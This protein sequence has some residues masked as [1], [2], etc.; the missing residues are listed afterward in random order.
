MDGFG[1]SGGL[2]RTRMA[3]FVQACFPYCNR[4]A[5]M[6]KRVLGATAMDGGS[7]ENAGAVFRP[8]AMDGGRSGL[9]PSRGI[10]P[11]MEGRSAEREAVSE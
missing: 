3:I 6:G 10:T 7:A 1:G 4:A 9:L 2:T 5:P 8:P 11:S